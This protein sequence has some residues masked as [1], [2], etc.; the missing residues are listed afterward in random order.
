M[1]ILSWIVGYVCYLVHNVVNSIPID[2]QAVCILRN[3]ISL[4]ESMVLFRFNSQPFP[5]I[6]LLSFFKFII[7]II[8]FIISCLKLLVA[9][10]ISSVLW[11]RLLDQSEHVANKYRQIRILIRLSFG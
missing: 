11:K 5:F 6:L 1:R 9:C 7:H 3:I 2:D 4:N 10:D 8:L